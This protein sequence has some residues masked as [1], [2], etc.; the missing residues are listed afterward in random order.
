MKINVELSKDQFNLLMQSLHLSAQQLGLQ[1]GPVIEV[2]AKL[3][4]SANN[5]SSNNE[6]FEILTN[7]E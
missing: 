3:Q 7:E 2:A 5:D 1:A 4:Q 6:N